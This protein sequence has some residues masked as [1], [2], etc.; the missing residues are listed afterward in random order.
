MMGHADDN[1]GIEE[2]DNPL[3]D[4]WVGLF[5][6][7]I[8]YGIGYAEST[9]TSCPSRPASSRCYEAGDAARGR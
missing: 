8:V 9:T 7:T 6:I 4:W 5:L 1:D 2:Y 3:P